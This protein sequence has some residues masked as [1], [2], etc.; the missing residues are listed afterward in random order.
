MMREKERGRMIADSVVART[1][2]LCYRLNM[3]NVTAN[4]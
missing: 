3:A 1:A 2:G 4:G